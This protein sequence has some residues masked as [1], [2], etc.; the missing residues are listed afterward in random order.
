[1]GGYATLVSL[2]GFVSNPIYVAYIIVSPCI[3]DSESYSYYC[4]ALTNEVI[5]SFVVIVS[6]I[7]TKDFI[8]SL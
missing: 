1:M 3:L 8:V 4:L 5:L 7:S 6:N 2:C